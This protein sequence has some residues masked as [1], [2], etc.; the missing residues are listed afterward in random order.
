MPA[1]PK[2][3]VVI[4][5]SSIGDILLATPL[6]R[7]LRRRFPATRIDGIVKTAYADLLRTNPHIDHL[8]TLDPAR[9]R[10]GLETLGET[11]A[12]LSCDLVI[13]IHKNFRSLA[14]RRHIRSARAV[15]LKKYY[16]KRWLLVKTG[17]NLYRDVVPVHRRYIDTVS[18]WGVRDD[19]QGLEFYVDPAAAVPMRARLAPLLQG[20]RVVGMAPG[21]G[22]ATKRWPAENYLQLARRMLQEQ[23]AAVMLLGGPGDAGITAAI[24]AELGAGVHDLA[25]QLSLM[26]SAAALTHC[27]LLVTND[28]G[29]MHLASALQV[30]LLALF[31]P[32]TRELGFFP[33]GTRSRV[34]EVEAL[35]CR[36]CTHMGNHRCPKK[37]FRCMREITV[38]V[39]ASCVVEELRQPV[40]PIL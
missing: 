5:L 34:L 8:W 38:D 17:W 11:L 16:L 1:D 26:E 33:L 3:I 36:P 29:L 2:H 22:F 32:T 9:G 25:G 35:S 4:R 27:D 19:G 7:V 23:G 13:D 24:S 6:L 39:V 40:I 10:A 21:A 14:L 15:V 20:R 28:T 18:A 37:H 12:A 31:G 30:P